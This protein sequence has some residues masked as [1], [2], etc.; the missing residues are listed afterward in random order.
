MAWF[1]D[2]SGMVLKSARLS[3]G[4][5]MVGRPDRS[6]HG[7]AYPES[8]MSGRSARCCS[9]DRVGREPVSWS[10]KLFVVR[11]VDASDGASPDKADWNVL[12]SYGQ[13]TGVWRY[14]PA[15]FLVLAVACLVVAGT[16]LNLRYLFYSFLFLGLCASSWI[17]RTPSVVITDEG[18]H[19]RSELTG[20]QRFA[21]WEM[22]RG[23]EERESWYG[24]RLELRTTDGRRYALRG[25]PWGRSFRDEFALLLK[26][27]GVLG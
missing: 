18:I 27:K 16:R 13:L 2:R 21:S 22:V 6:R 1:G 23:I 4:D 8:G 15:V 17:M 14:L 12:G 20:R 24:D 9:R 3:V 5:G 7:H 26:G 25:L 10:G 11:Q 19:V